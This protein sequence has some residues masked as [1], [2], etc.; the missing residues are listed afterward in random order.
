MIAICYRLP[1]L[2]SRAQR[3]VSGTLRLGSAPYPH[4]RS[5][6]GRSMCRSWLRV[7]GLWPL[8]RRHSAGKTRAPAA[9]VFSLLRL[10]HVAAKRQVSGKNGE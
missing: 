5:W 3:W 7:G 9:S 6:L 4:F 1:R 10:Q 8:R 2:L